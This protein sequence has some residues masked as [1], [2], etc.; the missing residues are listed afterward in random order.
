LI[1]AEI[2]PEHQNE[3]IKRGYE[4]GESRKI[5]GAHYDSDIQAGRIMAA[6]TVAAL[7]SN[8]A[9]QTQLAKAK[10]EF[11]KLKKAGKIKPS[12]VELK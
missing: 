8:A 5:V 10:E 2:N 12:T 6:A 4:I 7:H 11:A 9:F 1:L 3:I